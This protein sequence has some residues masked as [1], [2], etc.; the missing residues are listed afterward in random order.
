MHTQ[1]GLSIVATV[2]MMMILALFAAAVSH[3]NRS[4]HGIQRERGAQ[5]FTS[6]KAGCNTRSRKTLI[7][8][9]L[10][11]LRLSEISRLVIHCHCAYPGFKSEQP[12]KHP[13]INVSS[14]T[15]GFT[16]GYN[17]SDATQNQYWVVLCDT[18]SSAT[19][20]VSMSSDC[21]KINATR[22]LRNIHNTRK[23]KGQHRIHLRLI[24]NQM[25]LS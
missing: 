7:R 20:T 3:D 4:R 17:Y 8:I 15:D 1:S 11:Y 12:V 16:T 6:Q 18:S 5:A 22:K 19:P 14:S 23:G 24:T 10:L 25:P 9:M 21:E 2:M 13:T